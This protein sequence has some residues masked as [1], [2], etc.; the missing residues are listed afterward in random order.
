M[1]TP[2]FF[3][4]ILPLV[5]SSRREKDDLTDSVPTETRSKFAMLD[6]VR[7]LANGL[8]QLGHGL[9]DFVHKTKV[10]INE[11]FQKLNI[12]DKSFYDLSEQTSEIKEEEEELRKATS[13]LQANNEELK[14]M[15]HD[16]SAKIENLRQDKIQLQYK[17]E[18][19]E[20]KL[21]KFLQEQPKIHE[22][23]E[24]S[25][26]K[27]FVEQQ[28]ANIR[29]LLKIVQEQRLQLDQQHSQIRDLKE[30]VSNTSF[31]ESR[32][33]LPSTRKPQSKPKPSLLHDFAAEAGRQNDIPND[34]NDFYNG[35][36]RIPGIYSIQPNGS[37]IFNVYCEIT[38]DS[39]WTVIQRRIDG[40]LDFNQTWDSYANGFGDLNGEFWLGL[41]RLYAIAQQADYILHIELEDWGANKRYI[42]YTFTLGNKETDYM[43][44][45]SQTSGNIPSAMS[46]QT[47]I[48]FTTR[49]H[50]STAKRESNCPESYSGG[51]WHAEC[52]G[53][54]LNGKYMKPRPK[55]KVEKRGGLFWK[56]AKGRLYAVKSTKMM[57]R[58]ID[59]ENFD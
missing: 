40:S 27:N 47:E 29:Q 14:N 36:Q 16:I 26:L 54:N 32:R 8:L 13:K 18:D 41:E 31:Q 51:W 24:V 22:A 38:P 37:E 48:R 21:S 59:P 23:G 43:L 44:F 17:V 46:E 2:L 15:S 35:G 6:D 33:S 19:M 3:I 39:A 52:G 20:E 25:L 7:I 56:P 11:I 53:T 30:K 12:F 45:L 5:F 1:K 58:P 57:I 9:K 49:D 50:T 4:F 10:Q 28:D 34:C 42:E 55:G